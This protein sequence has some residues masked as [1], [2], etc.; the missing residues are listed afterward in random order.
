MG[1][2]IYVVVCVWLV[3]EIRQGMPADVQVSQPDLT[4]HVQGFSNLS[5]RA[6]NCDVI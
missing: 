2:R 5:E 6:D 4:A 1:Y 3:S